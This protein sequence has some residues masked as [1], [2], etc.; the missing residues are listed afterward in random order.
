MTSGLLPIALGLWIGAAGAIVFSSSTAAAND[1][2]TPAAEDIWT[3][4]ERSGWPKSLAPFQ[5]QFQSGRSYVALYKKL[6]TTTIDMR[7]PNRFKNS[8]ISNELTNKSSI[9]HMSIGWSCA[10]SATEPK[11]NP[12]AEGFAA[13]TGEDNN[14]SAEMLENGWGVT[15]LVSTFTDG[16]MQNGE[17]I[18]KYFADER[19]EKIE[20]GKDPNAYTALVVEVP[21]DECLKVRDF[22][23]S[24]VTH[25]SKPFI[26]F[27][28][29]LDP[30]RFEGAGC[31]SF[32]VAALS[33][34]SSLTSITEGLWRRLEIPEKL[35]GRRTRV[36]TPNNVEPAVAAKVSADQ[37]E[38]GKMK[39]ILLNWD[40][41]T[42]AMRLKLVDPELVI[43]A[44]RRLADQAWRRPRPTISG[45]PLTRSQEKQVSK[46]RRILN[47]S[48]SGYQE[49]DATLDSSFLKVADD[50]DHWLSK[51]Q[52]LPRL[53]TFD[54]GVGVFIAPSIDSAIAS[55]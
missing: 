23:K 26:N 16:R 14:Q 27:G 11:T 41:G 33:K 48:D 7:S 8:M 28:M 3:Q 53:V 18:Q 51:T 29:R 50:T 38:I 44:L 46:L 42:V 31:G 4:I 40:T 19:R 17:Q 39:L 1:T 30:E 20:A 9:G 37:Y 6:P 45:E 47:L 49:V 54:F 35:F 15:A 22:V 10:D 55:Q 24:Y 12:R 13:Q 2:S 5:R 43:Y 25:P 34:A 32:S 36:F 21:T 52:A